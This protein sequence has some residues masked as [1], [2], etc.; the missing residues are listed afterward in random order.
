[1]S[2]TEQNQLIRFRCRCGA[3]L[4]ARASLSGRKGKC[5]TCGAVQI[6]PRPEESLAKEEAPEEATGIQEMCSV[7]QTVIEDDDERT[8]CD[9]CNLPFHEECWTENLG[10]SAY[11]CT[12]VNALKEGPDIRVGQLAPA[13]LSRPYLA[14]KAPQPE[15][16]ELPWDHL[17]LGA[18]AIGTVVG[19]VTCGV[20]ALLITA[21]AA[22]RIAVN[23]RNAESIKLPVLSIVLCLLGVLVGLCLSLGFWSV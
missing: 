8:T 7:C 20:P 21:L 22:W 14:R 2:S 19:F 13:P 1:M 18:S 17:L 6:I 4:S 10:C 11:G 5:K 16:E 15:E 3:V 9:A 23:Q 12:N